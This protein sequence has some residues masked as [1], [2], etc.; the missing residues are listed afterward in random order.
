MVRKT[1]PPRDLVRQLLRYDADSGEF[2]WLP[3]PL[4]MFRSLR[5]QCSWNAKYAGSAAGHYNDLGYLR[6][7]VDDSIYM[8]HRLAW[9]FQ[10]GEPVPGVLD[11][12][13]GNPR[14]NGI[15]NLR[16]ATWSQNRANSAKI[17]NAL[18]HKGVGRSYNRFHARITEN[19]RRVELGRFSTA[20]EAAEAYHN[21]AIRL[22]GD[23]AGGR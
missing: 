10:H 11:H 13:D 8:A 17:N 4:E 6:I 20:E 18:G 19:G 16:A 1:L 22:Y 7:A 21:A 9:L 5:A 3:R 23:F 12:A 15:A 2:T 14:N